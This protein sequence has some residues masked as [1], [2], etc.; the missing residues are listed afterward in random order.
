MSATAGI[1]LTSN[2]A[3][4]KSEYALESNLADDGFATCSDGNIG[5]PSKNWPC[6]TDFVCRG[7]SHAGTP[8]ARHVHVWFAALGDGEERFRRVRHDT[9]RLALYPGPL[10]QREQQ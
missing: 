9:A 3:I 1:V 4:M 6:M 8:L 10:L 2:N 5:E 7:A